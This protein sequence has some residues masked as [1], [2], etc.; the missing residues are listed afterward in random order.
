MS[1]ADLAVAA[2]VDEQRIREY[3]SGGQQPLLS[4][5]AAIAGALETPLGELAGAAG[6]H[7]AGP[8]REPPCLRQGIEFITRG[9]SDGVLRI[10]GDDDAA[11]LLWAAQWLDEHRDWI[12]SGMQFRHPFQPGDRGLTATVILK[13]TSPGHPGPEGM[14]PLLGPWPHGVPPMPA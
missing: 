5:A 13:L 10:T 12:I 4:V 3:E 6:G 2:G 14:R 9:D 8:G 11:L 7:A 1:Q